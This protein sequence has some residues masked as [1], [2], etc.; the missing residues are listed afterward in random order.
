[1][2]RFQN[3]LRE[4]GATPRCVRRAVKAA[5]PSKSARPASAFGIATR[6]VRT[7]TGRS[8]RL[9]ASASRRKS[10]SVEASSISAPSWM[11][12]L[13]PPYRCGKSAQSA[14]VY[15]RFMKAYNRMPFA[16]AK[17]SAVLANF[18][19]IGRVENRLPR[20]DRLR[21]IKRV[22]SVESQ[23]QDLT[24]RYWCKCAKEFI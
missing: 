4:M 20:E 11:L 5:M 21:C 24:R 15:C 19:I 22:L 16:A 13:S 23:Y 8:I 1:M 18:S 14:C 12:A 17:L 2:L 7:N 10:I 6:I 9:S 3:L